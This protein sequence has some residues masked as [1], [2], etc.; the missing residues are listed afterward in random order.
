MDKM[1]KATIAID[2]DGT[3]TEFSDFPT[4]GKIRKD[5]PTFLRLLDVQG[6]RLV[7]NTCRT[8]K[9]FTEALSMLKQADLYDLFDWDYL[10]HRENFGI[11]GK[12][13]AGFY[14]DDSACMENF[15]DVDLMHMSDCIA[16][17]IKEKSKRHE[18]C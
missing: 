18:F 4:T 5:M 7:L 12:I 14:V 17:R 8:G 13:K 2:F 11:T 1:Y 10:R 6:Y 15:D 9:Y 3:I 16:K